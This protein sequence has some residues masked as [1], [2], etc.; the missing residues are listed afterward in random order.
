MIYFLRESENSRPKIFKIWDHQTDHQ[1]V[2]EAMPEAQKS[3]AQLELPEVRARFLRHY[4]RNRI[5]LAGTTEMLN[6]YDVI[7]PKTEP[8]DTDMFANWLNSLTNR[9]MAI[10]GAPI[11]D[12]KRPLV[13]D[14][15]LAPDYFL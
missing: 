2:E 5:E 6:N 13:I 9:S 1:L 3:R 14:L 8:S 7:T 10:A 11:L 15:I 4:N 12:F